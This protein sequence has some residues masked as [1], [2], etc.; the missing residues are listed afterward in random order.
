MQASIGLS[1]LNKLERFIEIRKKNYE[2]LKSGFSNFYCFDLITDSVSSDVSWF[3]FPV[4]VNDKAN[5]SRN[6]LLKHYE[7]H[8]I[9]TRLIFAGNILLQPA[10][11]N[12][13]DQKHNEFPVANNVVEN[14]FW[15]GVFPGLTKEML[16]YVLD[17]TS[18]FIEQSK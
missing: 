9:G 8:N 1:Q 15:L 14:A 18:E 5:F 11:S 16:L 17:V 13:T 4:L 10:Y 12:L 7:L 2:I 3:G 6:A